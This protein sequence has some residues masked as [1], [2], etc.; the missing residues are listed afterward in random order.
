[1]LTAVEKGAHCGALY[2]MR[3][4]M[5]VKPNFAAARSNTFA[6]KGSTSKRQFDKLGG[7]LK[8]TGERTTG[9]ACLLLS[10]SEG[11]INYR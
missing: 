7:E 9:N 11:E 2:K 4:L 10:D 5:R 1:L 8:E 6:R 3:Q